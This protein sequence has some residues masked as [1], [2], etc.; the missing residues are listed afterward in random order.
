MSGE[1][2]GWDNTSQQLLSSSQRHMTPRI[3]LI[4]H[5]VLPI[6]QFWSF[7]SNCCFQF[8]ILRAILFRIYCLIVWQKLV[9]QNTFPIPSD[10]EHD[11][12][13]EDR[14][15]GWL[16]VIHSAFLKIFSAQQ[17]NSTYLVC[18]LCG[19]FAFLVEEKH[20]LPI[21]HFVSFHI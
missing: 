2:D 6:R 4:K 21:M 1:Y 12:S 14:L 3:V 16:K 11:S 7:L 15:L 19:I 8:V 13:D 9:T 18:C 5:D 20:Q 17:L 10:T